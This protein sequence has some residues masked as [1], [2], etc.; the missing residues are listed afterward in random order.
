MARFTSKPWDGPRIQASLDAADYCA[1]CLI[2]INEGRD[3]VKANCKL[4][5]RA[6]PGGPYNINAIRN[7]MARIFQVRG[8][9]ADEKRKAARRL[10]RLARQAGIEV[11]SRALLRLA[12]LRAK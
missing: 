11:T 2:D 9:P 8:V 5:V 7:A 1:V 12:G 10:V 6:T 3:K 4:P